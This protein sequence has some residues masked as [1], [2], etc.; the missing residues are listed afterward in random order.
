MNNSQQNMINILKS[1]HRIEFFQPYTIPDRENDGGEVHKV[2]VNELNSLK[3]AVLPWLSIHTRHQ[4]NINSKKVRYTLYLGLFD[5]SLLSQVADK[6][7]G[8]DNDDNL[9][10]EIEQRLDNE[11]AT[12]FAKLFVDEYGVPDFDSM[13]VSTLPWALGHLYLKTTPN[14]SLQNYDTRCSLLKEQLDRI[15]VKMV[16]HPEEPLKKTLCANALEAICDSLYTWAEFGPDTDSEFKKQ[17]QFAFALDWKELKEKLPEV[18]DKA[19]QSD[20]ETESEDNDDE[21]IADNER[22]MPILNSFYINDIEK[23]IRSI[24]SGVC[25]RTLIDYL[26]IGSSK[27]ADLYSQKGLKLIIEHLAPVHMPAGRWPSDPAHNMSLMQQFAVNTAI[28]ALKDGGVLSVNG[29]PGTGK[30]T[31]LRDIIAHNMVER[32]KAL[33]GLSQAKDGLNEQGFLIQELTGF[34]MV[35]ASSNNAAVENISRELPQIKALGGLFKDIDYLKPVANFLNAE[36]RKGVFQPFKEKE[37]QCW[38]TISAVMGRKK[39][40]NKFVQRFL[41]GKPYVKG[42]DEEF[43]RSDSANFLNFWRW[44]ALHKGTDF[45]EA[46]NVFNSKLEEF[47]LIQKELQVIHE[48]IN[49]LNSTSYEAWLEHFLKCKKSAEIEYSQTQQKLSMQEVQLNF[50]NE[51]IDIED[52]RASE[53]VNCQPNLL[54]RLFN[55]RLYHDYKDKVSE[56]NQYRIQIKE[57][58]LLLK[59]EIE[60]IEFQLRLCKQQLDN[61]VSEL[62]RASNEYRFKQEQLQQYYQ[63]NPDK[64]VPNDRVNITDPTLQRNAYW[65][66]KKLN[67][68]RS[69]IFV[70]AMDL[71]Q[72]WICEVI[73]HN[74]FR[75]NIYNKLKD[76]LNGKSFANSDQVWQILFMIVP[77]ISTTFASLGLMFRGMGTDTL[78][79]LMVDEAG[80]AIPQAAV[81]GL[82]RSKRALVVGDPLQIEPVFTTPPKLVKYLS[83]SVLGCNGDYWNPNLLSIQKIADRMNPYGCELPVMD[84]LVW[85]GIPLWVH[86]RCIEPMFSLANQIAYDNRMIHGNDI[87]EIV[88]QLHSILGKNTWLISK[89]ECTVKQYKDELGIDTFN[90]LLELA[91]SDKSLSKVYVITPFK[92]VKKQLCQFIYLHR[93]QISQHLKGSAYEL[94]KWCESNIG[95]V[96]TFQGKENDTV[97]LVLGCDPDKDGGAVWAASKPNLLNV[98]LTRAKRNIYVIGDPGVW[99]DKEYFKYV[100]GELL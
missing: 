7:F 25:N 26:C 58:R 67:T 46:K 86:R 35:V 52:I 69:E 31:L 54:S 8:N 20:N 4:L 91:E 34:E 11:G 85:I 68:L 1:W 89:G 75:S 24:E 40:R 39:N 59:K 16:S 12:C 10:V 79:W 88:P 48:L 64:I 49:F 5:K 2:T 21:V 77:V 96:H 15:K 62:H 78:G 6:I 36:L 84:Q 53:L 99:Q 22:V 55:R 63:D 27:Y 100:A 44:K 82:L 50:L 80:Q 97:I 65:Q 33:A 73:S 81:G 57:K 32:G 95:T 51:Q 41:F 42:S 38:G 94:N 87:G 90:L 13:S 70:A 23:A 19:K 92:A 29:P 17:F 9:L 71:H 93:A 66:D 30:T 61:S 98:A 74:G 14:L 37:Q 60:Q 3:D 72:A 28:S 18:A 56:T 83:D 45:T 47:E 43:N 76:L